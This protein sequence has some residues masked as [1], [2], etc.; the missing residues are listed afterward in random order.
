MY[1]FVVN[2]D[3]EGFVLVALILHPVDALIGDKVGEIAFLL[4]GVAVHL[5]ES[6]VVV[7]A[8][9]RNNL[10]LVEACG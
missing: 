7:V 10:P 1:G 9:S 2:Q 5:D 8:L 4:Y 3:A 6:R